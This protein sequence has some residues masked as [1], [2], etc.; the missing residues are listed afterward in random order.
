M[1]GRLLSAG[2]VLVIGVVAV[3]VTTIVLGAVAF[4]VLGIAVSVVAFLVIL[5]RGLPSRRCWDRFCNRGEGDPAIAAPKGPD[6]GH[7]I[8]GAV[9]AGSLDSPAITPRARKP[10]DASSF[11]VRAAPRARPQGKR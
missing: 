9:V 1:E 7:R 4:L 6:R 8:R 3:V 10:S 2:G 11:A 5:I